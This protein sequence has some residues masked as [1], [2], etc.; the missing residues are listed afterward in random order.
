MN[1]QYQYAFRGLDE[2]ERDYDLCLIFGLKKVTSVNKIGHALA[3][4]WYVCE[5][6]F[7]KRRTM[8]V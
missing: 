8:C 3:T 6:I 2:G 5:Q 4:F 7:S 1:A